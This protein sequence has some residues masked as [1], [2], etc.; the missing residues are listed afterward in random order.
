MVLSQGFDVCDGASGGFAGPGREGLLSF[1]SFGHLIE[2]GEVMLRFILGAPEYFEDFGETF[3]IIGGHPFDP[4][5]LLGCVGNGAIVFGRPVVPSFE[6]TQSDHRVASFFENAETTPAIAVGND[7]V[8]GAMHENDG[9]VMGFGSEGGPVPDTTG[10]SEDTLNGFGF[11]SG[12]VKC[13]KGTLAMTIEESGVDLE[14]VFDFVVQTFEAGNVGIFAQKVKSTIAVGGCA[15]GNDDNVI[16]TE[17]SGR[18][19]G[20]SP[21]AGKV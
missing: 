11:C 20:K 13:E 2:G 3:G 14:E 12:I 6:R 16:G 9:L 18:M 21:G 17:L 15:I 7:G 1:D 5:E 10:V 8:F 4:G 19:I